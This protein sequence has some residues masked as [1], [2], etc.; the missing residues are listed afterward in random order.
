MSSWKTLGSL[1]MIGA[2]LSSVTEAGDTPRAREQVF[3]PLTDNDAW[4]RLPKP[5]KGSGQPLPIWARSLAAHMPRTTAA[6]LRL[7]Y[8]QRAK[9]PLDPKLRAAMRWVGAHANHCAYTEA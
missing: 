5:E 6:L 8:V 1:L 3:A 7:D 2:C 9:S 4:S